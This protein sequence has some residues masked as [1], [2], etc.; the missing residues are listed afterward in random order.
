MSPRVQVPETRPLRILFSMRNYWYV[1][2][3]EPVIRALTARGHEVHLLAER[4]TNDQAN[5]YREVAEALAAS[6]RGLSFSTAPRADDDRWYDLRLML[7]LA[8]DYLRFT[9]PEYQPLTQLVHRA[10]VRT[11]RWL[12]ALADSIV[13]RS[14]V[15]RALIIPA[16][17]GAER[18]VPPD[19]ALAA[20]IAERA[21]DVIAVTPLVELGSE[22][23]DVVRTGRS[24]G[25]P[26]VLCAG[27]WDHLSSKGL[28]RAMPDRVMVWND[29]QQREAIEMHGV[30]PA[31][32]EVTG[33]AVF[34]EWFDRRPTLDR[35]GFCQKVGLDPSRPYVLYT[36]SALFEGSQREAAF[37]SRW[38]S[39]VRADAELREVGILIRP[40]PKRAS[41]LTDVALVGDSGVAVWPPVATAP[42]AADSKADYFDSMFHAAAIVGLNTS[43][44]IE[45]GIAGRPVLTVLD[46]EFAGNQEGT[47]HFRY[48][49]EGGLLRTARVMDEH[50]RQLAAAV[51]APA[52]ARHNDA[53]VRSFVRPHGLDCPATPFAVKGIEAAAALRLAPVRDRLG[54]VSARALLAPIAYATAGRFAEQVARNRRRKIEDLEHAREREE[55]IARRAAERQQRLDEAERAREA[56]RAARE[57][58]RAERLALREAAKQREQAEKAAQL[59]DKAR[60]KAERLEQHRRQKRAA[61]GKP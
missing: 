57:A 19:P 18:V 13:G 44:L 26:T 8:L 53:F 39:A 60:Q 28:I 20:E 32:I 40:H 35:A 47:L 43:A 49:I 30:P 14:S 11:P 59:A 17:S 2:H 15:G 27:S 31:K 52:D 25:I 45:G 54:L 50:V 24:L 46:P 12:R 56:A 41:E 10:R 55:A 5:D 9:S 3:F 1:R 34:D 61:E 37:L 29:A 58:A 42:V 16:L 21:P 36:C 7:R 6:L 22:Q 51:A 23:A 48:L 38:M 33:A 4:A